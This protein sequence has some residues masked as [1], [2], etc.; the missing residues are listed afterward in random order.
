MFVWFS[1]TFSKAYADK[2]HLIDS[3]KVPVGIHI[4]DIGV[5]SETRIN[6]LGIYI[7]NK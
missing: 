3:S 4:S 5:T 7:D 6:F 1:E 2:C